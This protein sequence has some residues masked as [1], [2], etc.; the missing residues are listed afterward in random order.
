MEITKDHVELPTSEFSRGD[1][2]YYEEEDDH[3]AIII[4]GENKTHLHAF[5]LL[6]G[7]YL[8]I[9]RHPDYLNKIQLT[10]SRFWGKFIKRR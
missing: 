6:S 8:A 10:R 4:V 2:G 9:P 1:K 3:H 5:Y 7:E